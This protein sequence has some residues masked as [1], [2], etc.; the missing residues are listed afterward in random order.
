M[1]VTEAL[2]LYLA[3]GWNYSHSQLIEELG[4]HIGEVKWYAHPDDPR[5]LV[6]SPDLGDGEGASLHFAPSLDTTPKF[7]TSDPRSI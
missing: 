6:Y 7:F 4:K 3:A 2:E 5:Y 1:D